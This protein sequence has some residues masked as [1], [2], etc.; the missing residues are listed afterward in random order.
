MHCRRIVRARIEISPGCS[1]HIFT[2]CGK[3]SGRVP[4]KVASGADD[5]DAT[6]SAHFRK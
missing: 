3:Q 6:A 5:E 2:T 1:I 4:T